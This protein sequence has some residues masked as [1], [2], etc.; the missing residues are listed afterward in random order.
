MN[1]NDIVRKVIREQD[2]IFIKSLREN[3][4][5][6]VKGNIT[7]GKIKW[8]GIKLM[9]TMSPDGNYER[10]LTQRGKLISPVIRMNMIKPK[11]K[12]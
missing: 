11:L 7:Y 12:S 9:Q 3:A 4:V 2:K 1:T 8:R 6:P 5:P 10:F